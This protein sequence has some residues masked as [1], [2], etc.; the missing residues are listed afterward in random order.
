M[1]DEPQRDRDSLLGHDT[2]K[3]DSPPKPPAVEAGV[4]ANAQRPAVLQ[5]W[6][7]ELVMAVVS[8]IAFAAL[9]IILAVMD[10]KPAQHW[11]PL[12]LNSIN[13]LLTTVIGSSMAAIV[14]AALSQNLWNGFGQLRTSNG[15]TTRPAQDLQVYQDA[16]RGPAGSL[17]L[18]WRQGPL[19]VAALGAMVT[20]LSLAFATFTQQLIT[21]EVH[22]VID[23]TASAKPFPR[24]QRYAALEM[25]TGIE[26]GVNPYS[27]DFSTLSAIIG[28]G[29]GNVAQPLQAHCPSGDC[30]YPTDI[31]SLAV[32][33]SCT[34]VTDQLDNKGSCSWELPSCNK[35][36]PDGFGSSELCGAVG[37]PCNYKLPT[38]PTLTFQPGYNA[39]IVNDLFA[40]W[41][42]TNLAGTDGSFGPYHPAVPSI[43][44]NDTSR[45]YIMK[46]AAIGL[47]PSVADPYING[48]QG[49]SAATLPPMKAHECA[50]WLSLNYYNLSV[51]NG[52]TNYTVTQSFTDMGANNEQAGLNFIDPKSGLA[53]SDPPYY[54]LSNYEDRYALLTAT[55][56]LIPYNNS[57][58]VA[59]SSA[60][61][62]Y[63]FGPPDT[64]G[65]NLL[66]GVYRHSDNLQ[67][68]T[69][70]LAQAL[71]NNI[72]TVSPAPQ[73]ERYDGDVH[74]PQAYFKIRWYWI[75]LPGFVLVLSYVFLAAT[76][77]QTQRRLVQPWKSNVLVMASADMEDSVKIK[78]LNSGALSRPKGLQDTIGDTR[79][80]LH[81][82]A[83]EGLVFSS[84]KDT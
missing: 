35:T 1:A 8:L 58:V 55:M 27:V 19:S 24:S 14:G 43:A 44:Y 77:L 25:E 65:I 29:L 67:N 39:A 74:S 84:S 10:G 63:R 32:T 83:S 60:P 73:T 64:V 15:L 59:D 45:P 71:T 69:A 61:S 40:I 20:I 57:Y 75:S 52:T 12:T 66:E 33:G 81:G 18:L 11:G 62:H 38:G 34:D 23:T 26:D 4:G 56:N 76:I 13:S 9:V 50:M 48:S 70:N 78:I 54:G 36:G 17:I 28:A 53:I 72:A 79:V 68:W 49:V 82:A 31:P 21:S 22:N 41:N 30:T 42:A 2:D 51:K 3:L 80:G 6:Q 7:W 46:F 37:K 47:P 5:W 16:S